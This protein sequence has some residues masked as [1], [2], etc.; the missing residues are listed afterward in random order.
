MIFSKITK[1]PQQLMLDVGCGRGGTANYL[2]QK[3]WGNIVGIDINSEVLQVARQKYSATPFPVFLCCDVLDVKQTIKHVFTNE[4]K[5]DV[6]Y[7]IGALC[8]MPNHVKVL[9]TLREV[10]NDKAQLVIFDCIDYGEYLINNPYAENGK[11]LLPNCIKHNE[12]DKTF[13]TSGDYKR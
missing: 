6:I 7:I 8:L 2:Q 12:I 3:K 4:V 5:F 13:L 9:Q 1:N 11:I 10:A